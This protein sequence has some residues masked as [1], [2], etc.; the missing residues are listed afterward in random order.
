MSPAEARLWFRLRDRQIGFKF[1]RQAVIGE[2]IVDFVCPQA[3]M[4]V[5][6]D[7]VLHETSEAYDA[8]R[9]ASLEE[10]GYKVIRFTNRE[11][12]DALD[13]VV[14]AI[15]KECASKTGDPHP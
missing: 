6:L 7:G 10:L 2:F 13:F 8:A 1:R 14:E 9:T 3:R 4:I 15:A 11:V 12:A 5:E